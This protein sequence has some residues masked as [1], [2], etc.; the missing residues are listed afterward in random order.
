[1]TVVILSLLLSLSLAQTPPEPPAVSASTVSL[2]RAQ[3]LYDSAA[4]EEALSGLIA[5]EDTSNVAEVEE[6]RALCLLALGRTAEAE[7]A[8]EQIVLRKPLHVMSVSD[9][10]PRLILMFREVRQRM[11]PTV[12]R[13]LYAR[14][15]ANF[16]ARKYALAAPQLRELVTL[17][18]SDDPVTASEGLPELRQLAE[19]FLRLSSAEPVTPGGLAATSPRDEATRVYSSLDRTVV[20]P[21]E[22]VRWAPKAVDL[23]G[24]ERPGVYQ[25]LVEV[26]IDETGRV[27]SAEIRRSV[28]P[29]YDRSLME[30]IRNWRFQ[31]ATL[32]GVPVP[33]RKPFEI[34]VHSR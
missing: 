34:I 27:R 30:S 9:V 15:K 19:G 24:G 25:G 29:A 28:T 26:I 11:I 12:A 7:R 22:I 3:E 4:Y 20:G 14:A 6:Y 32:N 2:T 21:V 31:P 10:S 5:I 18:D 13:N 33:Y 23:A 16:D 1:M 17:L 8:L